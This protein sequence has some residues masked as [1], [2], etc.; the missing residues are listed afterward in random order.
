MS[1]KFSKKS[2]QSSKRK[3]KNRRNISRTSRDQTPEPAAAKPEI[4]TTSQDTTAIADDSYVAGDNLNNSMKNTDP[5]TNETIFFPPRDNKKNKSP[6]LNSLD[7]SPSADNEVSPLLTT[8][9]PIQ[10]FNLPDMESVK[11]VRSIK[12]QYEDVT[13]DIPGLIINEIL[14]HEEIVAGQSD[15][16]SNDL[17]SG[18]PPTYGSMANDKIITAEEPQMADY[19]KKLILVSMYLGI[20]LAALDVSVISTLL[21][22]IASEFNAL[23]KIT[24]IVS[25]YL[26]SSATV[27]PLYGKISDIYG[28]KSVLIVCNIIFALGCFLCGQPN[29]SFD[30]LIW[31]RILQGIGGSGLTSVATITTSDLVSLKDRAFYQGIGNFFYAIGIASG[32]VIGGILND[33]FNWRFSFMI[34]VPIS[35]LSLIMIIVFMKYTGLSNFQKL[36]AIDWTGSFVLM[37]FLFTFSYGGSYTM[38]F[39]SFVLLLLLTKI[40]TSLTSKEPILPIHFLKNKSVFGAAWSNFLVM[41]TSVTCMFYLPMY[42]TTILDLSTT[43]TGLRLAPN[44]FSTAFGSLGAG[45]YMKKTG[46]YYWFLMTFCLVG[47]LGCLRLVFIT[48][49]IVVWQQYLCLVVPGFAM[50]VMITINLLIMIA[51]V[52]QEDQAACTSISYAFRSTGSTVGISLAGLIFSKTLHSQLIKRVLPLAGEEHSKKTILSIIENAE[53]SSDY[54]KTAAEWVRPVLKTCFHYALKNTFIFTFVCFLLAT[55]FV[56]ICEEFQLYGK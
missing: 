45:L 54:I 42:W 30:Q 40:E 10:S 43:E 47:I 35:I 2:K 19:Q 52:P 11:S 23:D 12:S 4:T 15:L 44:F 5:G 7:S 18:T 39:I 37:A 22:H 20:L 8:S 28:R 21:S 50:S 46:K 55:S 17:E 1:K 6:N 13:N 3:N 29:N 32:G 25:A 9:K 27:Q 33:K 56:S 41:A 51:A 53:K 24:Q 16:L 31:G 26:L 34:Q 14:S 36:K 38:Y 48:P 49:D